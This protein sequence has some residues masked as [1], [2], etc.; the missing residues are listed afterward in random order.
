MTSQSANLERRGRL[1][2]DGKL[3][4]F[5]VILPDATSRWPARHL[6]TPEYFADR[7][8]HRRV[9]IDGKE[10]TVAEL[11]DLIDRS[12][13]E[14]PAPYLRAQ[15]LDA[16]LPELVQDIE[17]AIDDA[18]PNW[19]ESRLLPPSIRRYPRPEILLGGRGAGF[20]VL[21]YDVNHLHA[22]ISQIYGPKRL[23]FFSPDQT[24][25]L[26][27]LESAL[28]QSSVDIHAPDL[29]RFP[30]FAEAE[31]LTATLQPGETVFVPSGWWHTTLMD[32]TSISVTWNRVEASNW[33]NFAADTR[34][35]HTRRRN[36]AVG[37]AVG[38]YLA[39][40][41]ILSRARERIGRD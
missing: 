37:V 17:P 10:Y 5:P 18:R 2:R 22:F 21:H 31:M 34:R 15:K 13:P 8:G 3:P 41:G 25:R 23:F 24:E 4:E 26:Y 30:R 12:S 6:W 19:A 29:D 28:N 36:P 38:A 1:R 32:E 40:F 27:P 9:T 33:D 35:T 39:V 14:Q 7:V 11:L 20:H 16:V